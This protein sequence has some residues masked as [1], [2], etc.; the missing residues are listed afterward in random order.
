MAASEPSPTFPTETTSLL[1]E[2]EVEQEAGRQNTSKTQLYSPRYLLILVC[3]SIVA[4]DFG[5]SLGY[6][7]QLEIFES[8]LCKQL[9]GLG[10]TPNGDGRC[11]S[12]AVQDELALLNGWKDTFDQIPGIVL[13]FPYGLA[14]DRIGRKPVLLLS[15]FGLL[16]QEV[17]TRLISWLSMFD[18]VPLRAIWFTPV[19]QIVG[20]G[21][22]IATSMAYAM[23]TDRFRPDQRRAST[24]FIM[25][26]AILLGEILATPLSA[27]L[28]SWSPWIPSLAALGCQ[29]FGLL[30]ASWLPETQ[31]PST[32]G[33]IVDMPC[34][35]NGN[36]TSA[37]GQDPDHSS[38]GSNWTD[39]WAWRWEKAEGRKLLNPNMLF[40][41]GAFLMASIGRQAVQLIVQYASQR[42]EWSIA[43]ASL[44]ITIK[45]VINLVCLLIVLPRLSL[46]LSRRM[47]PAVKDLRIVQGSVLCLTLGATLMAFSARG[48][49][50]IAGV[51]VL[52]LGWGFYSALRSLAN[53]LGRPS[54][55][56]LINTM[57][58][59]AQSIGSMVAGPALAA[60]FQRGTALKGVWS[61][62]PYMVAATLFLTAGCL[63]LGI[64]IHR[65]QD[66][67]EPEEVNEALI[68]ESTQS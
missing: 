45:G 48:G 40:V 14:A 4:A 42:F 37:S 31:P 9:L 30:A 10:T 19:F 28:M 46:M 7:P 56:G 15:L 8:I 53:A 13:A 66:A 33:D 68:P 58:G 38:G 29:L 11:K 2:Q 1:A 61:G 55:I 16:F 12:P 65:K 63:T 60:A 25:A 50:F 67:I 32:T 64:R 52:A 49:V 17:A 27:L 59:F 3:M 41:V 35:A 23:I 43:R 39:S 6:A 18:V 26:A 51:S 36:G 62:L 24:F 44:L 21:P 34:D 20:G 22:E 47:S 57:I 54:Q 5:N